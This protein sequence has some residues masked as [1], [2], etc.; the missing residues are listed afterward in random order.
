M[1]QD[2][3]IIGI[4]GGIG[5][6]K[7]FV[8]KYIESKGYPVI[9]TDAIAKQL[10]NT[11]PKIRKNIIK[12]FGEESFKDGKYNEKYI[13]DIVFADNEDAQKSLNTL[14]AIIQPTVIEE[15]TRK[16]EEYAEREIPLVFIECALIYELDLEEGFEYV[17]S[18]YADEEKCIERTMKRS[19]LTREEVVRRINTQMPAEDKKNYADFVIDNN[20]SE[21][22]MKK[23]T[24]LILSF[25]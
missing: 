4:T 21:E 8:A 20:G 3:K 13:S 25:L 24:D 7:T 22:D 6:G 5:C 11:D 16:A 14:N 9:Y 17:L 15:M 1:E 19:K 12:N 23:A 18:V 2:T 10:V